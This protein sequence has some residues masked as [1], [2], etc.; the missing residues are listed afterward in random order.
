MAFVLGFSKL[1]SCV[2]MNAH[3]FEQDKDD[4][5][6]CDYEPYD[7]HSDIAGELKLFSAIVNRAVADAS[8]MTS[9]VPF[10]RVAGDE[11]NKDATEA[12]A[13]LLNDS[14]EAFSFLWLAE[15]LDL[16]DR[17]VDI[18]RGKVCKND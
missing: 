1:G 6:F 13:W 5:F 14:M 12:R 9:L 16:T 4:I 7:N 17:Q 11:Y 8:G 18:I 10:A 3:D 2:I 15:A